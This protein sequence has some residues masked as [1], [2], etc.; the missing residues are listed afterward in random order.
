MIEVRCNIVAFAVL[1]SCLNPC[2]LADSPPD[3]GI[4]FDGKGALA[5]PVDDVSLSRKTLS[6]SAWV[7]L[8]DATADQVFL[9]QGKANDNFT[10]YFY[11]GRVRMLV[12]HTAE[13]YTHANTAAPAAKTWTHYLGTYD[14][15]TI[16][17]YVNGKL[18]ATTDASGELNG[19]Q[20]DVFVGSLNDYE[21]LL[22]GRMTDIR[23]WNRTLTAEE[24][25][26][27]SA[28]RTGGALDDELLA[29]WIA[30]GRSNEG[31]LSASPGTLKAE[32][33][34][35]G[36]LLINEKCDGF[37]GIWYFNQLLPD[38]EYVYKYSGGLGTYC[39]KHIPLAWY[40][41]EAKKT[42]F[43]YGGT[44][45]AN[46]TLY[47]MV[48][49]YDH[50]TGMVA[51]PTTL[52]DKKT[53]DAHDNPVINIDDGG[54]IWIFS[55]SH[56]T[57]RPS[58]I[59][60]S[61][62]PHEIDEFEL[63][64]TGNFS[65]PQPWF[66]SGK[67]FLFLH[68]YYKGGRGLNTWTSTNG[69]DWTERTLISHIEMGHYQ[70]SFPCG[71]KLGTAFN[72]H[73]APKGLNWRTNLYYMQTDDFGASW[74]TAGGT[75]LDTPLEDAVNPALVADFKSK[76]R[77]VYMKD[78][79]YDSKGNPIILV[80]TSGGFES[81]PKNDP[82]TW[83]TARWTGGEWEIRDGFTSDNN[84]DMG[85][86][87]VE[88]DTRWRVVGPT[89]TGPQPY[90]PGGEIAMWLTEDAGDTWRMLR[91]MTSDSPFNHTYVRRPVNA[92]PDFYGLWADGHGREPTKSRLYY[93]NQ[94]GDVFMLP[95][96]MNT[97]FA[98]A[99]K[100]P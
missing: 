57:G 51:R 49:Y 46:S 80:I 100:L 83:I 41:P 90:N 89:Q 25:S 31:L 39:A 14:G 30:D 73:P 60:R 68:T 66:M 91:Q 32:P 5:V 98:R 53:T 69:A 42:F 77:N 74:K 37:R 61:V 21:R 2:L 76:G 36:N 12:R 18:A 58:F 97:P 3:E 15:R 29:R 56:G 43:C 70:V 78:V 22:T 71:D 45:D 84:Y 63:I 96:T 8:D 11:K 1:M 94:T 50:T 85:S 35:L 27:V 72:M 65:Y 4:L 48:S 47:H 99:R 82:R 67:G 86:L 33:R 38:S 19:K 55:S 17:L 87:Y 9:N 75:P 93:C 16:C 24:V 54:Y 34:K 40:A 44:D 10:F 92:S 62:K 79:N 95:E 23:I 59:S 6:F 26:A 52:L 13:A 7:K 81:G 28:G 64:W 88:S 20:S